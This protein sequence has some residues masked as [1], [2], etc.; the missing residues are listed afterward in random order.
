MKNISKLSLITLS[1][2]ALAGCSTLGM[3]DSSAASDA[4]KLLK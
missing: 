4:T 3:G 2:A 1:F